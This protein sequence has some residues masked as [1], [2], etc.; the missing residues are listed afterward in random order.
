VNIIMRPPG[1]AFARAISNHPRRA[2]LDPAK[3]VRQ[4]ET[5]RA[6]MTEAGAQIVLLEPDP[7]NPD[8][9]F[10]Q[11]VVVSFP[12]PG[13]A[14]GRSVL[15]VA[16]RPG[17][18][19][20]RPE[21]AAVAAAAQALVPAGCRLLTIDEP[22]TLEGGDV[23]LYGDRVVIGLSGRTNQAGAGQLAAPLREL[24]YKVFLCPVSNGRLHFAS[25]ITAVRPE[26]FIGVPVG[27]ADL[28]AVDPGVLPTAEIERI[29]ISEAELPAHNVVRIGDTVFM[30]AGNPLA[31]GMLRAAGERV[32]EVQFEQFTWADA[33]LTCLM[34][35]VY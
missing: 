15:L 27:F 34:C 22:G 28:D 11:D 26:R 18:P 35:V 1:E 33:G 21:V 13:D 17:A 9:P 19:S 10:V 30:P 5:L 16:T 24:G 29:V 6:A 12:A 31:A 25:A 20:R 14:S 4:H 32:T 2:E 7:V 23:L 3:A 8:A